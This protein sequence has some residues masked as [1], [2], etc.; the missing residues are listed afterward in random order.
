MADGDISLDVPEYCES[1]DEVEIIGVKQ[2]PPRSPAID[3]GVPGDPHDAPMLDAA[4]PEAS[5]RIWKPRRMPSKPLPRVMEV[6]TQNDTKDIDMALPLPGEEPPTSRTSAGTSMATEMRDRALRPLSP[7][8]R[9][10]QLPRISVRAPIE[11]DDSDDDAAQPTAQPSRPAKR[12]IAD[13]D[14]LFDD[15]MIPD[16]IPP[17]PVQPA[18]AKNSFYTKSNNGECA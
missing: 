18:V 16:P 7:G 11:L 3:G 5:Q 4:A 15:D 8:K 14:N 12:S 13:V 6:D 10:Q 2:S 17:Q 9:S 1:D